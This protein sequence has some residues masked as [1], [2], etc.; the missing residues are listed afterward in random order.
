MIGF[1]RSN[2]LA[3][4]ALAVSVVLITDPVWAKRS[5]SQRL[6]MA[7]HQCNAATESSR[8]VQACGKAAELRSSRSQTYIKLAKHLI[9]TLDPERAEEELARARPRFPGNDNIANAYENAR[10][11]AADEPFNIDLASPPP[12]RGD[13]PSDAFEPTTPAQHYAAQQA[14]K[15]EPKPDPR[16]RASANDR[17]TSHASQAQPPSGRPGLKE[18]LALLD[19]LKADGLISD[20]EYN[21]RHQA[22]MDAKFGPSPAQRQQT[23]ART[24]PD[25]LQGLKQNISFG[26]YQAL[27]IGNNRYKHL[28]NLETAVGDAK[29]VGTLLQARYGFDVTVVENANRYEIL[30]QLNRLRGD[31]GPND[32][33][34]IYYAGHGYR[35]PQTGRG[36][37]L[38]ID[39]ESDNTA[40]WIPNTEIT[41]ALKAMA[42]KHIMVVADSCYSGS[43][44]RS[45]NISLKNQNRGRAEYVKRMAEKRA[46]TVMTSGG[47]EPV[48]D[49][50]RNGHSVFANAFL[51]ALKES[52]TVVDGQSLFSAVQRPV[53]VNSAQTPEYSDIR[54]A[55]HEGG[56]FLFVPKD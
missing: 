40:N 42:A 32:N 34:L 46:R 50:G 47:I 10:R 15:S 35:D 14:A 26:R 48:V 13:R 41:D 33:L 6:N 56:D 8:I 16:P 18:Q 5:T 27:V 7:E 44:T 4:G 2:F 55:G 45:G 31:L 20:A 38:P 19:E 23:Q 29:A 30:T 24:E 12:G 17:P 53:I 28:T 9:L 37:W 49:S 39:A 25:D 11:A 21:E 3:I 22:L 52:K 54:F 36:Y 43:L 51:N 1:R